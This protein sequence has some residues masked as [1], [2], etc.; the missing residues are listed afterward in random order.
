MSTTTQT[1][2]IAELLTEDELYQELRA[3]HEYPK[4]VIL[5]EAL[6]KG[7]AARGAHPR[8]F[9]PYL[10]ASA[11][12]PYFRIDTSYPQWVHPQRRD[13]VFTDREPPAWPLLAE[14]IYTQE[15]ELRGVFYVVDA[16]KE[17]WTGTQGANGSMRRSR[18][19]PRSFLQ[20]Y[21]FADTKIFNVFGLEPPQP[22]WVEEAL[23]AG[24]TP[25]ANFRLNTAP[26]DPSEAT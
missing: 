1:A 25:P 3:G 13:V 23:E 14:G 7:I 10:V 17:I 9:E 4:P 26:R 20:R 15:D 11:H 18:I 8:G 22:D 16:E 24:W 6:R 2:A 21:S 12:E 5:L 19:A